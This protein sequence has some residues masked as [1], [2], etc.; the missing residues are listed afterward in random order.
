MLTKRRSNNFGL[1]ACEL[2]VWVVLKVRAAV[3]NQRTLN[4]K[5]AWLPFADIIPSRKRGGPGEGGV[6]GDDGHVEGSSKRGLGDVK[7]KV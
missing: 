6:A 4:N 2:E 7:R 3:K 5:W 1:V